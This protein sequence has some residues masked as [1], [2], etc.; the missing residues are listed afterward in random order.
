M[1]V[2]AFLS[3]LLQIPGRRDGLF[4]TGKSLKAQLGSGNIPRESS[5]RMLMTKVNAF[6]LSASL[7][8]AHA[9]LEDNF[10][11]YYRDVAGIKTTPDARFFAISS[12]I[13]TF[14]NTGK[15]LVL[16]FQVKHEQDLDCG[17]GYI[18]LLEGDVDQKAFGGDTPYR[19]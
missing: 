8:P 5:T 2:L 13:D 10:G 18:K 12:K 4:L 6:P 17:G 19:Y 1:E 14:D 16:Q 11:P 7:L 9:F 15:D 3:R